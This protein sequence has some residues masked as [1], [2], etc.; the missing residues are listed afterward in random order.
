MYSDGGERKGA[1]ARAGPPRCPP[2]PGCRRAPR[3][4]GRPRLEAPP[5]R[6]L[7][8]EVALHG[9]GVAGRCLLGVGAGVAER[10]A[11]TQQVPAAVELHLDA[12]QALLVLLER[13]GIG[14]V[15]LL[16]RA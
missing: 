11:L 5:H 8:L 15:G 2:P 1:R 3:G 4:S 7:L 12:A 14:T 9:A 10:S 13:G 6:R 16:A